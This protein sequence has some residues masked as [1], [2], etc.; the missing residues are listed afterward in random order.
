MKTTERQ[1]TD[2]QNN[3]FPADL[4]VPKELKKCILDVN[5]QSILKEIITA[6][7]LNPVEGSFYSGLCMDYLIYFTKNTSGF[8]R[9]LE[10]KSGIT[11]EKANLLAQEFKVKIIDRIISL[12]MAYNIDINQNNENVFFEHEKLKVTDRFIY[13][14][15]YKQRQPII[16]VSNIVLHKKFL[17]SN[18]IIYFEV[19]IPKE[20]SW[21]NI[22]R[23]SF[24]FSKND[25]L[26]CSDKLQKAISL[27][28]FRLMYE[29][30]LSYY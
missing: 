30:I 4:N 12:M 5:V 6:Y 14:S 24:V 16:N 19:F 7:K 29:N 28:E 8:I 26:R 18:Y 15:E 22:D 21:G 2:L 27:G 23:P 9:K 3:Y 17:S 11:H 25:A 20:G 13:Y 10:S 1:S